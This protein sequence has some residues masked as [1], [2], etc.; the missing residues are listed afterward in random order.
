MNMVGDTDANGLCVVFCFISVR[1]ADA[2]Q[3]GWC[4]VVRHF[5]HRHLKSVHINQFSEVVP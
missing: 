2:V 4:E 1:I 5:L 3:F